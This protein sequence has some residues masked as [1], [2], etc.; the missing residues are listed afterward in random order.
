VDDSI[1][2]DGI[3]AMAVHWD[4]IVIL[5]TVDRLQRQVSGGAPLSAVNGLDLIREIT[6]TYAP[7]QQMCAGLL[8]ELLIARD[9]DLL[10]FRVDP[11]PNGD[12]PGPGTDP[13]YYL[14]LVWQFALT[15]AGQDRARGQ[16]IKQPLPDPS[17]DD[18]RTIS[19]LTLSLIS[20]S[21][22]RQYR[23]EQLPRFLREAGISHGQIPSAHGVSKDDVEGVLVALVDAGSEARR[24]LR[25]FI[26]R[27]L[28]D[29][30]SVG[31]D[32]E[33]YDQITRRLAREGWFVR[34][35]TLVIGEPVRTRNRASRDPAVE[36]DAAGAAQVGGLHPSL[37]KPARLLRDGH[38]AQAALDAMQLVEARIKE[39]AVRGGPLP[40]DTSYGHRLATHAFNPS[41][42]PILDVSRSA[43]GHD[44]A[45][46][47]GSKFL[48][49]GAMAALRN[50]LAH[51]AYQPTDPVEAWELVVFASLLMRSLDL[52][53]QRLTR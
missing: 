43:H 46:Q 49:M 28:D 40:A 5:Q 47:E 51:K 33:E 41:N 26:A 31:P 8:Q 39:L 1:N 25:R 6:G 44:G 4:N 11:L 9:A 19:G 10:A 34:D 3:S 45:E 32:D 16:L 2:V 27:W 37:D 30:L 24:D 48:F 29:E 21:I 52:A 53:E 36:P 15:V 13:H 12:A 42:G 22:S 14:Q 17:E 20:A 50:P 35:G 23:P 18:G 38:P 7:D